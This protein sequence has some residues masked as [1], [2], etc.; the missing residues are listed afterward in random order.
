MPHM[1]RRLLRLIRVLLPAF[2]VAA[3]WAMWWLSPERPLREWRLD[4][5][6][7]VQGVGFDYKLTK[8]KI[9]TTNLL[10]FSQLS[11]LSGA[12]DNWTS[13]DWQFDIAS[14]QFTRL[15]DQS[16]SLKFSLTGSDYG[17]AHLRGYYRPS[18]NN[19]ECYR[20][21]GLPPSKATRDDSGWEFFDPDWE[22]DV[23]RH[24]C[25]KT[26]T[27]G[28]P[29]VSRDFR[30]LVLG[31]ERSNS[32]PVR[33]FLR[34]WKIWDRG[35]DLHLCVFNVSTGRFIN[36]VPSLDVIR[37]TDNCDQFWTVDTMY[38]FQGEPKGVAV[39]LWSV[40]AAPPPWWLWSL[41]VIGVVW[42]VHRAWRWR[43]VVPTSP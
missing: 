28:V 10:S 19:V 15:P 2:I 18:P 3:A 17:T 23:I 37:W 16:G 26:T 39:R 14:G 29:H 21:A 20:D 13:D 11:K 22:G 41:S 27:C 8:A 33:R 30:W 6:F 40:Y 42:Y 38:S 5:P 4:G 7:G 32:N 34:E 24:R 12:G 1:F 25:A 9:H 43:R 36:D 35:D 31:E